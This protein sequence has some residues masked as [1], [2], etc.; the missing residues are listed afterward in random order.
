LNHKTKNKP[1]NQSNKRTHK[2]LHKPFP[3][4]GLNWPPATQ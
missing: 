2:Q 3:H 4:R 1:T